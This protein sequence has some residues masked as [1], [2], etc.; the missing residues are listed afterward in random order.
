MGCQA[1]QLARL[2][3]WSKVLQFDI[4]M[5]I[6]H[7]LKFVMS[8]C[9]MQQP[10]RSIVDRLTDTDRQI[11]RD[12]QVDADRQTDRHRQAGRQAGRQTITF[13]GMHAEGQFLCTSLCNIKGKVS[14]LVDA[15]KNR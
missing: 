8:L 10:L 2:T 4:A 11:L 6:F 5:L 15:N 1:F 7:S 3:E 12:R 14:V 13:S 9:Q